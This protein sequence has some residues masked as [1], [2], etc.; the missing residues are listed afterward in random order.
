M[1]HRDPALSML[2]IGFHAVSGCNYVDVIGSKG[3]SNLEDH[4][5]TSKSGSV[6]E[7]RLPRI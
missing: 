5:F 3:L 6:L 7:G 1:S 4:V 2:C